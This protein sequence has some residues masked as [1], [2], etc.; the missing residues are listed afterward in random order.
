MLQSDF[1]LVPLPLKFSFQLTNWILGQNLDIRI[2]SYFDTSGQ[3]RPPE[4]DFG[5]QRGAIF[6][7][8]A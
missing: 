1:R 4:R 3:C 2:T 7:V 6:P 5:M 8:R